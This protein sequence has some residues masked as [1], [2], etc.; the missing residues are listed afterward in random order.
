VPAAQ[1]PPL[2]QLVAPVQ[3]FPPQQRLAPPTPQPVPSVTGVPVHE[4]PVQASLALHSTSQFEQKLPEPHWVKLAVTQL[5]PLQ[6]LPA[7]Q[8]TVPQHASPLLQQRPLQQPEPLGQVS[9]G[10]QSPC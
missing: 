4:P 7:P 1:L 6:H 2:Q 8:Q 10:M 5:P 3:Q 9:P